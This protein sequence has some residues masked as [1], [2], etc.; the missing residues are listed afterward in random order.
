MSPP[1]SSKRAK[2]SQRRHSSA[3]LSGARILELEAI[4]AAQQKFRERILTGFERDPQKPSGSSTLRYAVRRD[5]QR[6]SCRYPVLNLVDAAGAAEMQQL[7]KLVPPRERANALVRGS[8]R[9]S[10]AP[11]RE[12]CP[13]SGIS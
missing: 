7:L 13:S 6:S 9:I 12:A 1:A 10:S 4:A 3:R 11:P 8:L 2:R 5:L